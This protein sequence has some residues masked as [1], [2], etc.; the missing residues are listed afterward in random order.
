MARHNVTLFFQGHDHLYAHQQLDGI[1]YQ[2]VPMPSDFTYSADNAQHYTS[3]TRLP[4]SGFLHVQVSPDSVTVEYRRSFLPR[5]ESPRQQ[6]GSLAHSYTL[7]SPK[8]ASP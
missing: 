7:R 1:T 4:N 3:G 5:D 8:S 6:H 2:T